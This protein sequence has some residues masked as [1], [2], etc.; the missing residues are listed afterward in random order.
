MFDQKTERNFQRIMST[1]M[2]EPLSHDKQ[3]NSERI[4]KYRERCANHRLIEYR[5]DGQVKYAVGINE[6]EARQRM[7]IEA[8]AD[9]CEILNIGPVEAKA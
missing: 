1:P 3:L 8:G 7:L 9:D 6:A 2:Q 4:R 5:H